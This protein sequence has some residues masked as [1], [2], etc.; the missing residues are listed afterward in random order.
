MGGADV[1]YDSKGRVTFG[2]QTA[3]KYNFKG[4]VSKTIT[5]MGWE[6]KYTYDSKG[7]IKK[8]KAYWSGETDKSNV[9]KIKN[10]YKGSRPI[11]RVVKVKNGFGRGD[12]KY[13]YKYTYKKISVNSKYLSKVKKQQQYITGKCIVTGYHDAMLE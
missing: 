8:E 9:T 6:T 2:D 13:T 11:K 12:S 10:T 5:E 7:F 3:Y 4:R 1:E